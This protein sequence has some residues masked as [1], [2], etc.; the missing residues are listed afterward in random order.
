MKIKE[1]KQKTKVKSLNLKKRKK[2]GFFANSKNIF[3]T[4]GNKF[5]KETVTNAISLS[6]KEL[7]NF[8]SLVKDNTPLEFP[9][10]I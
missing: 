1:K 8:G 2:E 9:R 10:K 5:I 3:I 7:K 4:L 6:K